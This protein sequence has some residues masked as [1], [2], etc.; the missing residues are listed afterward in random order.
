MKRIVVIA[1]SAMAAGG[2]PAHAAL[3][4]YWESSKVLHAILGSNDLADALKQ[5]PI[6]SLTSTDEGYRIESQ[7]CSVNV[8]V[9]RKE[10]NRP[11]PG[12]F[13]I[14]IGAALCR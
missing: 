6:T 11:G 9:T 2:G 13:E 5:Q 7:D 1:L 8:E 12:S 4:G 10:A 14:R 3:S